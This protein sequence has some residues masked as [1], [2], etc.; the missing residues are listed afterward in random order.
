[1]TVENDALKTVA[2]LM[3]LAARTAP[4]ARGQDELLYKVLNA[5]RSGHLGLACKGREGPGSRIFY[6]GTQRILPLRKPA[7]SS[8]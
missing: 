7:C 6:P 2:G 1:M 3:I 5:K 4:K 8:G